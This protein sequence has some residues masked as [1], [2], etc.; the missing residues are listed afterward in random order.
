MT[1]TSSGKRQSGNPATQAKI[2]LTVKQQREQ[3]KREKLGRDLT[4]AEKQA[5]VRRAG[6]V[7]QARMAKQR[8]T[9]GSDWL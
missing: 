9:Q 3:Q 1:P 7:L 5:Q 6:H 8:P 2:E 4:D